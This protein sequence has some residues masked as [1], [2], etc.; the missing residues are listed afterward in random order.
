MKPMKTQI[1]PL[2]FKIIRQNNNYILQKI[3]NILGLNF[4]FIALHNYL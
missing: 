4:F 2:K 3:K 1:S